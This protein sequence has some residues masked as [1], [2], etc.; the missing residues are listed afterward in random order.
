[1][2][3]DD[4]VEQI[5]HA[6]HFGSEDNE[7]DDSTQIALKI[8]EDDEKV[9]VKYF[10]LKHEILLLKA[11]DENLDKLK[12]IFE[13][14]NDVLINFNLLPT[15][16]E[17]YICISYA[18]KDYDSCQKYL[19]SLKA[20]MDKLEK[21]KDDGNSV[22]LLEKI[23]TNYNTYIKM[24]KDKTV[25]VEKGS[26]DTLVKHFLTDDFEATGKEIQI[27]IIMKQGRVGRA[28]AIKY[29]KDL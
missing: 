28:T 9:I 27:R 1:M 7:D 12:G 15:Y 25:L 16:Y 5:Y 29:L 4:F 24:L 8:S 11:D 22:L 13:R 26:K 10:H 17:V 6:N 19:R 20:C 23:T 14:L 3:V 21:V 18:L 2:I